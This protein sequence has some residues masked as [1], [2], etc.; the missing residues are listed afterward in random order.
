MGYNSI[1][2]EG[3]ASIIQSVIDANLCHQAVVTVRPCF[4]GGYRSLTSQLPSGV[5]KLYS[6]K[7]A[8]IGG[9]IVVFGK[10]NS[11][12]CNFIN[13]IEGTY[14]T[15]DVGNFDR[16]AVKLIGEGHTHT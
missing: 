9:D 1:L 5:A 16:C 13:D 10:F 2:V 11:K 7:V 8:S 3:G 6:C 15:D 12:D 14:D 4:L